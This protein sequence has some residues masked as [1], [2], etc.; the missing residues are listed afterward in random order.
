[1]RQEG[2]CECCTRG[3]LA[4]LQQLPRQ[5]VDDGDGEDRDTDPH[6]RLGVRD[7]DVEAAC[8]EADEEDRDRRTGEG[9]RQPVVVEVEGDVE[10]VSQQASDELVDGPAL[11]Q[12]KRVPPERRGADDRAHG[13]GHQHQE[14][15]HPG[16]DVV[17]EPDLCL[18]DA[19]WLWVL[20]RESFG[21]HGDANG[22]CVSVTSGRFS[23]EETKK[24][25][26]RSGRPLPK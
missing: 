6:Q 17:A 16:M 26:G 14:T 12:R 18:G 22:S 25:A 1:M 7:R 21:T 11:V 20:Q 5:Q 2:E 15:G 19:E 24:R 3:P 9:Q 10:A 23:A 13:G 8:H 4:A